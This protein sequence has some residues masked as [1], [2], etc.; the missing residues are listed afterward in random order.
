VAEREG[1]RRRLEWAVRHLE[2]FGHRGSASDHERRA[3]EWLRE[4]LRQIGLE[5]RCESFAGCR[6]YGARILLHVAGAALALPL[7]W[8]APLAASLLAL[9]VLLSF[10]A[11]T[12][13]RARVLTRL[14]PPAP[15]TNVVGRLAGDGPPRRRLVLCA[16]IDTQR[17]GLIWDP[18]IVRRFAL[19][20]K[21]TVGPARAPLFGMTLALTAQLALSLVAWAGVVPPWAV[22]IV[23]GLVYLAA[24]V[25]LAEWAVRQYVP[26]ACDNATGVAAALEL[27][28]R[29]SAQ[30]AAGVELVVLLPGSEETGCLGSAAWL[31]AHRHQLR[32]V[33]TQFLNLDT[34]GYGRP[35]YLHSECGLSG[36][37]RRYPRALLDGCA[38]VAA[39]LDLDGAGPHRLPTQTDGL[40]FLARGIPGITLT[41]FEDGMRLPHYHCLSDRA[42][43][44]DFDVTCQ[45]TEFAW[46]LLLVLTRDGADRP[47]ARRTVTPARDAAHS[48]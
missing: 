7:I 15:S 34:L 23:L 18:A 39:A 47:T 10:L 6:S 38:R 17:T 46:Q 21:R 37:L 3:A 33:P 24:A 19:V 9:V 43:H 30:P 8:Y 42:E 22:G 20:H 16:H 14:L 5:A 4:Q 11:E 45:A 31:D 41:T 13:T 12:T 29:W 44:L 27:A 2:S 25:L 40:S 36:V 28:R 48:G 32:S 26:G 1:C 35:R